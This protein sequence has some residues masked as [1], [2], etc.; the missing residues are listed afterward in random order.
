VRQAEGDDSGVTPMC[1]PEALNRRIVAHQETG[2]KRLL[3]A[4]ASDRMERRHFTEHILE[5]VDRQLP[6]NGVV[7]MGRRNIG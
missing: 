1:C 4:L 6:R 5:M 7:S 3:F 2:K